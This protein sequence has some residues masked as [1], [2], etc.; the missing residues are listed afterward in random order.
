M[1]N[2]RNRINTF[3]KEYD[4]DHFDS[5]ITMSKDDMH[6]RD[7][8]MTAYESLWFTM[9]Y[10]EDNST[11]YKW[12]SDLY[13]DLADY[14]QDDHITYKWQSA[15]MGNIVENFGDVVRQA[16]DSLVNYHTIDIRW[17][18]CRKGF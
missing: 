12:M 1:K 2:L 16:W 9:E 5:T 4:T 14:M 18:Y 3:Y 13:A 8:L 7:A 10:Y 17:H 11:E 15:T 6:N